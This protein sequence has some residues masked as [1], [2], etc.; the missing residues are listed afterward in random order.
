MAKRLFYGRP[1]YVKISDPVVDRTQTAGLKGRDSTGHGDEHY[2]FHFP[3]N[4]SCLWLCMM[5]AVV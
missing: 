2:L 4:K 5:D 1:S 3:I